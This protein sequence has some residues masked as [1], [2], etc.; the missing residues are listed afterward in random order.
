MRDVAPKASSAANSAKDVDGNEIRC[1][2][3]ESARTRFISPYGP[4]VAEMQCKCC[5]C[6][7]GFGWLKW[8]HRLPD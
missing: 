7:Q 8:E 3:C 6:G 5:D 4:S 2:W 1:P